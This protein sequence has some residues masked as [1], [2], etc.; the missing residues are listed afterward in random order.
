MKIITVPHAT[1][2]KTAQPVTQ[3]DKKIKQFVADLGQTLAAT[4]MPKGVGLA[5]P[6]INTLWRMFA[7]QL[8]EGVKGDTRGKDLPT[9]LRVYINPEVADFSDEITFGPNPEDP[10][11]EGCLSI[12]G[13]YG[14]VPR[15]Q[16][17]EI[18]Y[19]EL[20]GDELVNSTQRFED[21]AARVIQH[22]YDHLNGVLFIDSTIKYDLPLYKEN[23][24]SKLQEL[25][26]E[27][28]AALHLQTLINQ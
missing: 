8:P 16:W 2:R 7:T 15:H 4:K 27:M 10:I 11:L 19:Q 17:I 5:A 14:P 13:F 28:V 25:E 3:L 20:V 23:R 1:L 9:R 6:Q 21:F 18:R 26:P 24:T 12:P 22:E